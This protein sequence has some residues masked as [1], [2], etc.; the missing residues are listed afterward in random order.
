MSIYDSQKKA[1]SKYRKT[2]YDTIT[3]TM[4]KGKR[5]IIKQYAQKQNTSLNIFINTAIDE[6]INQLENDHDS[7]TDDKSP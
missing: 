2:H 4:E 3:L 7:K 5:D 1:V 6:K